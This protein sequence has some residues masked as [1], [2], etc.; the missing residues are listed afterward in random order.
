MALAYFNLTIEDGILLNLLEFIK[1]QDEFE[2]PFDVT[3]PGI[4]EILGIRRSHVSYA[5]KGL[6]AKGFVAERVAHVKKIVRK[7]KTYFLTADGV[8]HARKIKANVKGQEISLIKKSGAPLK[9]KFSE[10]KSKSPTKLSFLQLMNLTTPEGT[11]NLNSIKHQETEDKITKLIDPGV[12]NPVHFIDPMPQT[13]RFVG[14]ADELSEMKTWLS[15]P[16]PRVIVLKGIPGIGKTTLTAR[17]IE[18]EVKENERD[19]FWFRVHEWDTLRGILTELAEFLWQIGRQKLK[20]YLDSQPDLA[21]GDL[22]KI[23]ET[24]LENLNAILVFD[25]FQKIDRNPKQLFSLFIELLDLENLSKLK[26]MVITRTE[27]EFYDRREVAINKLVVELGLHG[28]DHEESKQ[29]LNLENV[30][31]EDFQKIFKL[32]AGHPLSIEL[33]SI[34]MKEKAKVNNANLLESDLD[35]GELFKDHHDINKYIREEIFLRLTEPEKKLLEIISV[36]RY[37]APAEAIFIE[38]DISHEC[39]DSLVN[40]SLLHETSLGYEVHELIKEFFYHR[41]KPQTKT[42]YHIT[43]ANF[44]SEELNLE[45]RIGN[46]DLAQTTNSVLEA[47]YHN[48]SSSAYKKAGDL[49]AEFGDRL[50]RHGYGDELIAIL[51]ELSPGKVSEDTW[52]WLLIHKGHILTINGEWD[53]AMLC[54]KESLE[55]SKAHNDITGMARA[56][57]AIGVIHYRKGNYELAMNNYSE[58]LRF[59]LQENDDFDCSKIYSN[60]AVVHW[61]DGQLDRAI[62]LNKKSL[63]IS[64]MLRDKVGIA[65]AYNNL[66]IIYWEQRQLDDAIKTYNRS[67]ELSEELGDKR[68]IAI[69]YDNLGEVYRVKGS[70]KKARDFYKK[71]LNLSE[72]L[73]FKWQIAEVNYNLGL[74]YRPSNEKKSSDFLNTALEMYETL[75]AR[76]EV[77]KVKELMHR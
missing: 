67:L 25:D 41:L 70:I 20:F 38:P 31:D 18:N 12:R 26:L 24:D 16:L 59:A 48:I 33:I 36:Y 66:G 32:T 47:I 19:L 51:Y 58:G 61:S 1:S 49:A 77:K 69:L 54:Y 15:S 45:P 5:L 72:E 9:I 76:R 71:S 52:P 74:M 2:V 3:Q 7:R 10:V 27:A 4:A 23:L 39:I 21:L 57:N 35:L 6:K 30:R 68:T 34:H 37:P 14:R 40:D 75:G 43:A 22:R 17:L 60:M 13:G 8:D 28:L 56:Y 62:D 65:R 29:L 11:L 44:Y 50:I 73:G 42:K 64:E 63:Q 46:T 55:W 53:S